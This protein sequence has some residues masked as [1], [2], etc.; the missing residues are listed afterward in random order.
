M[1]SQVSV[2]VI[3]LVKTLENVDL[4]SQ[5]QGIQKSQGNIEVRDFYFNNRL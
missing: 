5:A 1:E 4:F 2:T 3:H